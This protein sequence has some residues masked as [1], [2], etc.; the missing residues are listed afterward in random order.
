MTEPS[1]RERLLELADAYAPIMAKGPASQIKKLFFNRHPFSYF[2]AQAGLRLLAPSRD[3]LAETFWSRRLT[4][5]SGDW[6]S[7]YLYYYGILGRQEYPLIKFFIRNLR[8]N[9]VFY[10]I[11]ANYGFY[12]FLAE[13]LITEGEIHAF[14]PSPRVF[15]YLKRNAR[16]GSGRLFLNQ[17]ALS[18]EA[19]DQIAFYDSFGSKH[20]GASTLSK[21]VAA[22][23]LSAG[24]DR[25]KVKA[26]TLDEYARTHR[27]PAVIKID[28]EGAEEAVIRGGLHTLA[29]EG[30]TVVME[31]WSGRIGEELS[32]KAAERLEQM[33]YRGYKI[34]FEGNLKPADR[35]SLSKSQGIENIVF[36][37]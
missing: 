16:E 21:E 25:I 12:S 3:V 19:A 32:L 6:D 13:E 2:L 18:D 17:A 24:Y 9:D 28:V 27:K 7:R 8:S 22:S 10:D 34:D 11:G 1:T 29:E 4:L 5:P 36:R 15:D 26:L 31:V 23:G 30:P 35:T 14:E 37:L 33:G 20:S